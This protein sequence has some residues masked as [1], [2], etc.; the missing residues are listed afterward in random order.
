MSTTID[1]DLAR[2]LELGEH[3]VKRATD[4]G[5]TVAECTLRSGAELSAK[6]RL[7]ETELVEEAGH[8]AAGLR[9][10]KGKRV[11]M[12]STSDFSEFG[13]SRFVAFALVLLPVGGGVSR[14]AAAHGP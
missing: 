5:A 1:Q 3:I 7:G 12:T 8:R 13:L 10:M 6:V 2:L 9:L 4:G 14:K 11:A